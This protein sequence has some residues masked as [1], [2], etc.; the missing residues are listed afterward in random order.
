LF[1]EPGRLE[2][3]VTTDVHPSQ[4]NHECHAFLL[5]APL[6]NCSTRPDNNWST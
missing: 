6:D 1:G 5:L 4:K 2:A 3:P